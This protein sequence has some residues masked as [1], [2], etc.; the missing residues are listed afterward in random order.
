MGDWI[1]L[2]LPI[3]V[4]IGGLAIALDCRNFGLWVYDLMARWSPGGGIDPSFSPDVLRAIAGLLGTILLVAAGAQAVDRLQ[5]RPEP[6]DRQ[7]PAGM[8]QTVHAPPPDFR[9]P[10]G[11]RCHF[12]SAALRSCSRCSWCR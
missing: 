12:A 11:E 10:A 3:A 8:P 1:P 9:I 5:P 6:S 7:R 4:G 2:M